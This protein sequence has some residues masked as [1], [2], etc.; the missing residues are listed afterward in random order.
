[1]KV[2]I[3]RDETGN[4]SDWIFIWKFPGVLD[5][6]KGEWSG[7]KQ[8]GSMFIKTFKALLGFTPCKGSIE[9]L[10]TQAKRTK[11]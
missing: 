7:G 3:T 10:D 6:V 1:M 2:I 11:G 4:F 5:K 8:E 9:I